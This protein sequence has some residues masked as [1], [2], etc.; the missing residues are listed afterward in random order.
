MYI[1]NFAGLAMREIIKYNTIFK[2]VLVTA[3]KNVIEKQIAL[4]SSIGII[5]KFYKDKISHR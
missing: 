4:I 1:S 5:C 2:F 3:T